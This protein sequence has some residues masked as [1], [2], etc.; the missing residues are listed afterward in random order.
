MQIKAACQRYFSKGMSNKE[1]FDR[2]IENNKCQNPAS[3]R[4][5]IR[6]NRTKYTR[7]ADR[8]TIVRTLCKHPG[9]VI[10]DLADTINK[11][12]DKTKKI[13]QELIDD[14]YSIKF[15][16]EKIFLDLHSAA[17]GKNITINKAFSNEVARIGVL[18]DTH[19]GSKYQSLSLVKKA[20][21]IFDQ[22]NVDLVCLPGDIFDGVRM[23]NRHQFE[24]WTES[25]DEIH[26]YVAQRFPR[27]SDGGKTYVIRGNHD[28]SFQKRAGLDVVA[29][30]A[31]DRPDIINIG[32]F[33]AS[34]RLEQLDMT[35][36]MGHPSK[37]IAYARSY[38]PQKIAEAIAHEALQKARLAVETLSL[39]NSIPHVLLLGHWHNRCMISY[40]GMEVM[41]V[42][43]MQQ[44]TPFAQSKGYPCSLEVMVLHC[45]RGTDAELV[46]G[47]S[48][49]RPEIYS[50]NRFVKE[51]DY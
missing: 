5:S 16:G 10:P 2:L 50:L 7:Q 8:A 40:L 9:I 35:I 17:Q 34:I 28:F 22:A 43:G 37:G 33:I 26:S 41:A 46:N 12:E 3:L 30:L 6:K 21:E 45:Y 24:V 23:Y 19:L 48:R 29:R 47:L 4:R 32:D 44:Q 49:I 51:R 14:G 25:A 42:A 39:T 18:S 15:E 38:N 31:K 20:Y 13:I 1:I 11:P 27:L 36:G